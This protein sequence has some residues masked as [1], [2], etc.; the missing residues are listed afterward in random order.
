MAN[1][2]VMKPLPLLPNWKS[3]WLGRSM[4]NVMT[5][6][7]PHIKGMSLFANLSPFFAEGI[8]NNM[9]SKMRYPPPFTAPSM[10]AQMLVKARAFLS[11]G[12]CLRS[13]TEEMKLSDVI[14]TIG[15]Y[16][17]ALLIMRDEGRTAQSAM[18]NRPQGA[19]FIA[20]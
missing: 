4:S 12:L 10:K 15:S 20:R 6:T 1:E 18:T 19:F 9:G 11:S 8:M 13:R 7:I 2:A 17:N 5:D 3:S 16:E 14:N